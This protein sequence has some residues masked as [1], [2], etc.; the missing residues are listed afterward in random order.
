MLFHRKISKHLEKRVNSFKSEESK[1]EKRGSK[2][3]VNLFRIWVVPASL[4]LI[5]LGIVS[6]II[7]HEEIAQNVYQSQGMYI[8]IFPTFFKSQ[9]HFPTINVKIS[10]FSF[11]ASRYLL[12]YINRYT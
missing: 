8:Y 7:F 9:P 11:K 10:R 5:T 1:K 3:Y 12:T 6:T 4:V 2:C